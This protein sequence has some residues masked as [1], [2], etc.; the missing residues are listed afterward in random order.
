VAVARN[1]QGLRTHERLNLQSLDVTSSDDPTSVLTNTD[2]AVF[3]IRLAP[4]RE[5]L[6]APA[7]VRFLDAAASTNTRVIVIG[8]AAPLR[9]PNHSEGLVADDPV[10]VPA[11]WHA[12]AQ[13][14][15]A[16]FK[17]CREHPNNGWAYLS[18]PALLERG[19]AP[20]PTGE[21]PPTC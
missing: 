6:L 4:G 7:T 14:S 18:P 3:T 2:A 16:Q 12:I 20:A 5:R 13:A 17:A 11:E 8:G 15:L 9:S 10:Y 21:G 19:P 1:P